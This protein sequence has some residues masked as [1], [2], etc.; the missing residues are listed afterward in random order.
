M[1]RNSNTCYSVD[2]LQKRYG[3]QKKSVAKDQI[4]YDDMGGDRAG[5]EVS[6][7]GTGEKC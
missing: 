2:E 3:K 5:R 7:M 1:E 6:A 4:L